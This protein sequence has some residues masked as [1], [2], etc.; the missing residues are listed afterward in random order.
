M[1]K[2]DICMLT[3]EFPLE[4]N[5]Y[6]QQAETVDLNQ[7]EDRSCSIPGWGSGSSSDALQ[8]S[9][10]IVSYSV[11]EDDDCM[12]NWRPGK[13]DPNTMVCGSYN[14]CERDEGG[15]LFCPSADDLV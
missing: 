6:V 11:Y 13:Y 14:T 12:D 4:F 8:D 10:N 5:E 9:L 15:P 3:L 2:S 1:G 7:Y